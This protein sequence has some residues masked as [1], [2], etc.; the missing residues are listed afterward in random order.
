MEFQVEGTGCITITREL[1]APRELVW[2]LWTDPNQYMCW[3]GPK[4]FTSPYARFDLHMG[5]K[6]LSCMRG[7]DGKEYWD[8]GTYE[9]INEPSRIVYTDTFADQNGNVVPAS[10]YGLGPDKPLELAVEVT[11][12]NIGGKTRLIV[13]QCGLP[14]GEMVDQAREGWN[15]SFDKLARCLG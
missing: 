4:D 8:A 14:E 9:E 12:E 7:Q 15:Q 2:D 5:G 11:L 6:D 1:D 13:E 10:Y 3:W